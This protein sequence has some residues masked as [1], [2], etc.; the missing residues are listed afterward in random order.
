MSASRI[1]AGLSVRFFARLWGRKIGNRL[2]GNA[3][4]LFWRD[5]EAV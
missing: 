1:G 3:R 5:G 4:P 2:A